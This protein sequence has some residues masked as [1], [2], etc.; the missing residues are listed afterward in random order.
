[1]AVFNGTAA[2]LAELTRKHW[3]SGVVAETRRWPFVWSEARLFR[4]RSAWNGL[5]GIPGQ[6]VTTAASIIF[7]AAMVWLARKDNARVSMSS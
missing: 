5:E 3:G 1:M 7:S 6:D 4:Q 2:E